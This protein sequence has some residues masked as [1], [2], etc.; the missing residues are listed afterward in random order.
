MDYIC[1]FIFGLLTGALGGAFVYRNNQKKGEAV[2]TA[3]EDSIA[4]AK[5]ALK[6]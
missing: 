5:S 4:K 6:K 1:V 3:T 2:L